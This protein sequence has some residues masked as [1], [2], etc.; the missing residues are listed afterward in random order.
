[1]SR[2]FWLHYLLVLTFSALWERFF[3]VEKFS[4]YISL[5]KE[6]LLIY[7]LSAFIACT[8]SAGFPFIGAGIGTIPTT[9][10]FAAP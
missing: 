1:M 8:C 2:F 9:A 5:Y 3:F 7:A 6:E 4:L 10:V